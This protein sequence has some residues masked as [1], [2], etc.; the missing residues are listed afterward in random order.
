MITG[1]DFYADPFE[2]EGG[3]Y[4]VSESP[5]TR[6]WVCMDKHDPRKMI[7][8]H[9]HHIDPLL[10]LNKLERTETS[11]QRF[12]DW[13][14]VASWDPKTYWDKILP[15]RLNGDEKYIRKQIN[16]SDNEQFRTFERKI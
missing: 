13:R 15:A 9:V 3:G 7:I 16:A 2:A 10:E 11:G 14:K 5:A 1:A 12:G 8:R 6:T 4:L